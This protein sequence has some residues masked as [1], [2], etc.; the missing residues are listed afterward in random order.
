MS[1]V[2]THRYRSSWPPGPIRYNVVLAVVVVATGMARQYYYN[3][4]NLSF[5]IISRF[6][7][8]V[9]F[10]QPDL[11][12]TVSDAFDHTGFQRKYR[13]KDS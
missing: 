7:I 5:N 12:I 10:F 13:L 1:G 11:H 3:F 9:D 8:V 6:E 4:T 2:H